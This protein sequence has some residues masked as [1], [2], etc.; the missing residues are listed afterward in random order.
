MKV[1]VLVRPVETHYPYSEIVRGLKAAGLH[2][3]IDTPSMRETDYQNSAVIT[4]NDYGRSS[5]YAH[6]VRT[7]GGVHLSVENS[8]TAGLRKK[9]TPRLCAVS[10]GA[11][12]YINENF[13]NN[14]IKLRGTDN[15]Y[16]LLEDKIKRPTATSDAPVLVCG[17]RGGNYSNLAMPDSWPEKI[18]SSLIAGGCKEI[19]FKPHPDANEH[20]YRHLKTTYR[21]VKI[22]SMPLAALFRN[23]PISVVHTWSSSASTVSVYH[24]IKTVVHGPRIPLGD[25]SN[26]D[27]VKRLQQ[28]VASEF[29]WFELS[30]GKMWE[31]IFAATKRE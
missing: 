2:V 30:D 6:H 7:H 10:L 27:L 14:L 1:Y 31:L 19:L 4:W 21:A 24:G 29:T 17:Q 8:F 22:V 9:H 5:K 23:V 20:T 28:M 18:I 25:L 13:T 11:H 3:Q 26:L 15:L 12:H 16:K